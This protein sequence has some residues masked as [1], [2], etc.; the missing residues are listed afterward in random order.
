MML[1]RGY[2][3]LGHPERN[4]SILDLERWRGV[5]Y[6]RSMKVTRLIVDLDPDEH[7]R[8]YAESRRRRVAPADI[9]LD[10]VRALPD[11]DSRTRS[12]GALARLRQSRAEQP[13][14][15]EEAIE[16]TLAEGPAELE[17]QTFAGSEPAA[18]PVTRETL[19]DL[20]HSH[21]S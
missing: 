20:L 14:V 6:D 9:V 21:S 1:A 18:I 7:G 13:P 17:R 11:P 5:T 3:G 10:L 4:A 15:S 2:E 8:L 16:R 12:L 19:S